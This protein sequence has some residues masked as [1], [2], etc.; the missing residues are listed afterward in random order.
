MLI[1]EP[2]LEIQGRRFEMLRT[3]AG[4]RH[5]WPFGQAGGTK[6]SRVELGF[7]AIGLPCAS[8]E[9]VLAT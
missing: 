5:A 3:H 1:N 2:F 9:A 7:V 4:H 8:F 6:T